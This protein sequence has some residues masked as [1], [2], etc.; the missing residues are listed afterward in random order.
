MNQTMDKDLQPTPGAGPVSKM[1]KN[2]LDIGQ[3]IRG[4][5]GNASQLLAGKN[6]KNTSLKQQ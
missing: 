6:A 4:A 2:K 5:G 3:G 1:T